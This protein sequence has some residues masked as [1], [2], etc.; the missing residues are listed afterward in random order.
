MSRY[1]ATSETKGSSTLQFQE[2]YCPSHP[3][4]YSVGKHKHVKQQL[5]LSQLQSITTNRRTR[6]NVP[7]LDVRKDD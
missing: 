1:R 3:E 2:Q 7:M 6:G 4:G 5:A